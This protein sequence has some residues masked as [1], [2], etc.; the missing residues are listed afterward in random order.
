MVFVINLVKKYCVQKAVCKNIILKKN[1]LR[2]LCVPK[3]LCSSTL[4]G[5]DGE[6]VTLLMIAL[7]RVE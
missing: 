7:F 5:F 3:H 2:V 4:M 6:G 1:K